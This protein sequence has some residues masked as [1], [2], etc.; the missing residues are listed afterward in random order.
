MEFKRLINRVYWGPMDWDCDKVRA[1]VLKL[2]VQD[3]SQ[4]RVQNAEEI[5]R[6]SCTG[7]PVMGAT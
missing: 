5:A 2:W 1:H 6:V 3:T 4:Y 7:A